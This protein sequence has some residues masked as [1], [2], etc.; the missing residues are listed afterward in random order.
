M[1]T[2]A[3]K[4]RVLIVD[5]HP[6]VLA[7]VGEILGE[8][9]SIEI[10]GVAADATE[11]LELAR[12]GCPDV[13]FLDVRLGKNSGFELITQMRQTFPLAECVALS[14]S[15]DAECFRDAMDRGVHG[16]LLDDA[17]RDEIRL[18]VQ[19]VAAGKSHIDPAVSGYLVRPTSRGSNSGESM[20]TLREIDILR[21]AAQGMT[22]DAIARRLNLRIDTVKTHMSRAFERIGAHDRANAVA[23]CM[24]RG[25]F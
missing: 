4:V 13:V 6:L 9:V 22:N 2:A 21:L 7:G 24:R 1:A 3:T 17:S 5:D 14:V 18:A 16:Y 8:D 10:I 15:D 11:A 25:L 12:T 19:R 20:P 23:I